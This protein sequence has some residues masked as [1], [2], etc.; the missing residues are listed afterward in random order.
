M[1]FLL[2]FP[3]IGVVPALSDILAFCNRGVDGNGDCEVT[4]Q[5]HTFCVG[6][7]SQPLLM[8]FPIH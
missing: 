2:V 1:R 6:I 3:L 5:L 8:P 7:G 4:D